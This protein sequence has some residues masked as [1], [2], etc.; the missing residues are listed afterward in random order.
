MASTSALDKKV[1]RI[2]RAAKKANLD[3]NVYF[4]STLERY[5]QQIKILEELSAAIEEH[6]PMVEKEYVKGRPNICINPAV[7]EYNKTASAANNTVSTLIKIVDTLG[8]SSVLEL[9]IEEDEL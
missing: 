5:M 4:V 7:S 6:G 1:R 2:I 3:T 8:M 9:E